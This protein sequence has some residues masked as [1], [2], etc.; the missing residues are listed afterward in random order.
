M[1]AVYISLLMLASI[2]R[3]LAFAAVFASL[4]CARGGTGAREPRASAP[5]VSGELRNLTFD[6]TALY[7][8]MGL[9][10]RGEPFPVVG[11]MAYL[12]GPTPDTTHLAVALSFSPSAL[13]FSRQADN[14]FQAQYTLSLVATDESGRR[15]LELEV[16]EPVI[17]GSFRETE[18]S[19]ESIVHQEIVD[20]A[21]GRYNLTL[22]LRD[23]SSQRGVVEELTLTVPRHE[24]GRLSS[25][26]PV[27]QILARAT[28]DSLPFLLMRPRGSAVFGQDS[29]LPLYVEGYGLSS[30][31]VEL[32]ARGES[33]S[34]LWRD[35][36]TLGR[37]G[38]LYA[39]VAEVEVA[40]LGV[41]VSELGFVSAASDTSR[42]YVFIGFG[43]GLP[44]VRFDDMLGFLRFFASVQRI[45]TLRS[46]PE[47]QRPAAWATFL[48][49]TDS[50]P[51]T[52]EHE[53][54]RAYFERLVRAN[55]RFREE[56]T[57]GW[58]TDRGRVFLVMGEPTAIYEPT[59][60]D[61][62][63]G[64]QQLWEYRERGIQ[65]VFYDQT[66][67]ERWRLTQNSEVRF[68]Q[69][70]RRNLR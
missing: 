34:L 24:G 58:L 33:G 14:R 8:Q 25:P 62:Q 40:R 61:F 57:P 21:P 68:E 9:I 31:R 28:R 16:T 52:P 3:A 60:G 26:V 53:D 69:E 38:E 1:A 48:R 51:E 37:S 17:V 43:P 13:R 2:Q 66:G 54:L 47:A 50:L 4:A 30:A 23:V 20:L 56:G 55:S 46:I 42:T 29:V 65:L 18:R 41:G 19:D 67:T 39:T 5:S 10:A 35:T 70:F 22:A 15:A 36:L 59:V 12:A 32:F 44:V 7:R 64:R 6:P 49:E 27:N 45:E 11:R 63:R